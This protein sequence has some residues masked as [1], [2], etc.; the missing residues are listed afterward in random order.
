MARAATKVCVFGSGSFG[1][2]LGAVIARNG[3]TVTLLTRREE[4]SASINTKHCNPVHLSEHKLPP[5]L[6]ATTEAAEALRG[7]SF[8]VHSIPVQSTAEFLEPLK[9]LIP[10]DVPIISTSKG[11]HSETLET[12]ADLVPRVLGRPQPM[13]FL[14]GPTFAKEL[15]EAYPSGAIMASSDLALAEKCA[16]LFSC[17][18]M[19][20]YTTDDVIG[21]EVGGALKNVY[22]LAAGAVE[23]MGLGVNTV[24]FLVT[25]A[26]AEMNQLA[27]AMGGKAHTMNGLAG[28]GDLMLTCMGG[29]SR[30]KAVGARIGKG[31]TLDSIL[32]SRKES[33]AGVAEGVA[34]TPAA[35]KLAAAA[36]V[37]AP[38]INAIARVLEGKAQIREV[39]LSLMTSTPAGLDFAANAYAME[40]RREERDQVVSKAHF[41][42]PVA[43]QAAV[44]GVLAM[45]ILRKGP[46]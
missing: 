1:T 7:V 28:I 19:R 10:E 30:N 21:V 41:W 33:L 32:N 17:A 9:V 36:G 40:R 44:L 11:L 42:F 26:C 13:A 35:S 24:A 43:A 4:V 29:A 14:S 8:I 2:A 34:T 45:Y 38:L 23:G 5:L 37:E 27:V 25:R 31:E 18:S 15:M 3:Y 20:V 22:A 16:A 12:M 46:S 39:A 6:G